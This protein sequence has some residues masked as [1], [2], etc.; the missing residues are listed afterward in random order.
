[1]NFTAV[2]TPDQTIA[3]AVATLKDVPTP[4]L[5]THRTMLFLWKSAAV[6]MALAATIVLGQAAEPTF[7]AAPTASPTSPDG[8]FPLSAVHRGLQGVAYTVF[9]GTQPEAMQV[10]ILGVLHNALGPHRDMIL[11]RLKGTKPEYT[12]VVAGM[13]GSPVYIDG[14]LLGALSYRI[15]QFSKEPIAG[16]TPIA[17][18]LAVRD[19]AQPTGALEASFKPAAETGLGDA[20]IRPI[21]TPLSLSG[22]SPDALKP[23]RDRLAAVGLT[24]VDGVGGGA[25]IGDVAGRPIVPGSSVSALMVRGDLEMAAS[26]TVTYVDP[27]QLLACGHPISQYGGISMPMTKDDV[28]AT[29]ASPLNAFKIINTAEPIGAFNEDRASAIRGTFGESAKMIPVTLTLTEEKKAKTL[30]FDVVDNAQ[31]TPL[32]VLLSTYQAM[33]ASNQYGVEMSYRVRGSIATSAGEPVK[34]D[35]FETPSELIPS[36]IATA[37]ALGDRFTRVYTNRTRTMAVKSV[38]LDIEALPGNRGLELESAATTQ[39]TAH[40]G[41]SVTIDAVMRPF[42]A[43]EKHVPITVT[44]PATLN[45]GPVRVVLSGAAELD[46]ILQAP[47]PLG[48]SD[49]D[50]NATIAELNAT[51]TNNA[52]YATLL[53]PGAQAVLDGRTLTTL[54]ISMVN[55]MEP[56]RNSHKMQLN[57]ESAVVSAT[58]PMDGQVTGQQV[59]T[60]EVE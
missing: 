11:A 3:D 7:P 59:V 55:V 53:L 14:K 23:F 13:S 16:I 44:L 25:A 30:H 21:E 49:L 52:L 29:L 48:H 40:A 19:E 34:L 2:H 35:A 33:L 45:P 56:L 36:A 31:M 47:T 12:G 17:D 58:E 54:P 37:I 39:P 9:E 51:H 10:E 50:V 15:G 24:A 26:C 4:S 43:A 41:E 22:F 32:L 57:G 18:M 27:K 28:V 6:S 60:I 1:L 20:E 38:S 46:R 5:D 8:Y 42:H